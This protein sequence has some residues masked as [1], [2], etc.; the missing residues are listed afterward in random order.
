MTKST[1]GREKKHRA[2]YRKRRRPLK[3]VER[4]VAEQW[5]K[6]WWP[7]GQWEITGLFD[8]GFSFYFTS[9]SSGAKSVEHFCSTTEMSNHTNYPDL[10]SMKMGG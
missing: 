9:V 4:A 10:Q 3:I 5:M 6:Y 7:L 8:K 1:R 2:T